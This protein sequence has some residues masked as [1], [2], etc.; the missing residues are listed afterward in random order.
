M[1]AQG[2]YSSLSPDGRN[3]DGRIWESGYPAVVTGESLGMIVFANFINPEDA[4]RLIFGY[5]FQ[6]ELDPSR[7]EKRNILDPCLKEA[8]IGVESGAL[9]LGGAQWNVYLATCD[10]GAV[11]S[12]PEAAFFQLINQARENPLEM[13]ASLGMD[14]EQVLADFPEWHDLLTHGLPPLTFNTTLAE[15]ARAHAADMLARGYY[16]H[17]SLD[18]RTVEERIREAGY[19]PL[20]VGEAL[21]QKCL[22]S[23]DLLLNDFLANNNEQVERLVQQIFKSIFTRELWPN[24][25]EE[26]NILNVSMEEVGIGL[27]AGISPALGGICG[28]RVLLLVIDFGSSAEI[29]I[30]LQCPIGQ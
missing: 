8:G 24:N 3:Y 13:A 18:G 2:Y 25:P 29:E 28:D 17:D 19:D 23:D 12:C 15:A 9:G 6:D 11:M 27:A 14:P 5:M 16:S 7:T 22:G 10:F 30:P 26:K 1:F 4:V 21:R 20:I